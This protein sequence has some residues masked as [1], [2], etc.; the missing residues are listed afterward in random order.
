MK[1]LICKL[2]GHSFLPEL[3][4]SEE[5][6]LLQSFDCKNCNEKC[7]TDGYGRIV[8]FDRYW[9]KNHH[10]FQLHFSKVTPRH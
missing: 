6:N 5:P 7:T 2:T 10:F 4:N 1:H 9:E 3:S 8:K